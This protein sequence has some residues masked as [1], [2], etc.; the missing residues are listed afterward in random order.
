MTKFMKEIKDLELVRLNIQLTKKC[1]QR[2]KSCNSYELDCADE[3]SCKEIKRVIQECCALYPIQNIAFTG[4]EPTI[5][6]DILELAEWGGRFSPKVSI[7]TNGYFCNSKERTFA[8][9]DAGINR[10]SFSYH[11]VG[12]Q[13][14]FSGLAG[15]ESRIRQAVDWLLEKKKELPGLYIKVAT[16]FNGRNIDDVESVLEYAE[17]KNLDLYIEIMEDSLFFLQKAKNILWDYQGEQEKRILELAL[18]QISKW[19]E[20]GRKILIDSAGIEF[21]RRYLGRDLPIRGGCPLGYTDLYIESNGNVRTGCW[22]LE[23]VGNIKNNSVAEI[24][25]GILYKN[26]RDKM[27]NRECR[28][29]TCGYLM[30]AKYMELV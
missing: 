3:M 8:L 5:H 21:M 11:G 13:D 7:T 9:V 6:R 19:K 25:N 17:S 27:M 2:C 22:Q 24:V 12:K 18:L 14:E 15:S 4:G 1:N 28:G 26:N 10:F 30:Q 29:C 20:E 16:L 23:A